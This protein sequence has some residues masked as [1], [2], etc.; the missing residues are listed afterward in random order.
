MLFVI[1]RMS[2]FRDPKMVPR[3]A[4]GFDRLDFIVGTN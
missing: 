3:Y 1:D 2:K 4:F